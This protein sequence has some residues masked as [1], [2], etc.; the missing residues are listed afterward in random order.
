MRTSLS[1]TTPLKPDEALSDAQRQAV[2]DRFDGTL[3]SCL[4]N[5][6]DGCIILIMQRLHEDDLLGHVQGMEPWKVLRFPAIAEK[7]EV[8]V[9]QSSYGPRRFERRAGEA[10][11]SER[12]P[13][14]T[15]LIEDRASGTQLIQELI[16]EGMHARVTVQNLLIASRGRKKQN[17]LGYCRWIVS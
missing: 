10:L 8:H 12:E 5:K 14:Q 4:N 15:V 2:N 1:S 13:S 6:K 16:A 17:E 7:D 11:Q 9:I 3:Y